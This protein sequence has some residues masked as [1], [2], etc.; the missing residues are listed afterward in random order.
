MNGWVHAE[1][2]PVNN[3]VNERIR[4][5]TALEADHTSKA[6]KD[7]K[8]ALATLADDM[9]GAPSEYHLGSDL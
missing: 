9:V 6:H 8:E 5:L 1:D 3:R 4:Q 2:D 7:L